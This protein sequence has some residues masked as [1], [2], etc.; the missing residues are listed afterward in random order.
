MVVS[1][2]VLGVEMFSKFK[3]LTYRVLLIGN[4]IVILLMLFVGNI[5]RLNPV[6]YPSLANLGLGF[7]ILLVFNLVFLGVWCFCR[8]RSVWLPLLGFILCYGPIRTYS[9]FNFPEDKPHGSIKVLSYN[10]F[11]FSSWDEPHGAKNP[12]VDYIVKS[13]ADIVCL[14]EAQA[15]LDNGD[16][17]YSTLKKHYPYFKLMIKKH[18]GADYIVL[19]SK[20][21]VLWQ[22]TI[23]YGSSSNQSVAYMLDIKGTKTLVVNN[24]FESNGLSSG[25]KE[26]F[27]TLVK[28][29]LKT[30]EAKKQSAHLIKKLGDVSARRA[31]QAEAVARFVKKYLDKQIPVILCG[32][33]NDSP[34]SYTHHVI[35][36][37]LNDCYVESGNGPG[38]SYHKSGMYFRIDHI[39]CSDDFE[40]YGAK[41]DNSVTTSDH[42]PIY[43]WLKYRPKP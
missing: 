13:K 1:T 31:P 2:S 5:G 23:P 29:E 37:E 14:Q 16:Q 28:G 4:I 15:R 33:F 25:D 21:P 3:K 12:I 19:L 42:Y 7:P 35:S 27:K 32:D 6:D 24:H 18:P 10:V 17:I 41:V 36:K 38:I 30:D 22:D 39:F 26:G 8:L 20:Y 9:P 11:M 43:C 34:L 40:S